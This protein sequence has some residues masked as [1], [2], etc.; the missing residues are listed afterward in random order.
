MSLKRNGNELFVCSKH[1]CT[2]AIANNSSVKTVIKEHFLLDS[3]R[4]SDHQQNKQIL[5]PANAP[6]K[7][8]LY[9]LFL[10]L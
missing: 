10:T 5:N 7:D 9:I 2:K 4:Q 3:S 8:I 1:G 6:I